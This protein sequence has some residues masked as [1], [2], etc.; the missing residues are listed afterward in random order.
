VKGGQIY[1]ILQSGTH[2]LSTNNI[3]L[4]N[5][6]INLPF[7][8]VSPFQAE[9]WFINL[10]AKL[11]IKWETPSP[12]QIEDPIYEV[13]VPVQS[14]GQYGLRVTDPELFLRSFV[15]NASSTTVD[16]MD[17][18]FKG[19]ILS[20]LSTLVSKK[21]VEDKVS[22]T[23]ITTHLMDISEFCNEKLG[24]VLD[25]WG[26]EVLEFA[27]V[28]ISP[29]E[30]DPSYV[31]LKEAKDLAMKYKIAG[32][33]IQQMERSFGVMDRMA[34]NEGSGGQFMSM[35]AGLGAGIGVGGAMGNMFAQNLNTNPQAAPPAMPPPMPAAA[36]Y[37]ININGAQQGPYPVQS[38]LP[39]LQNGQANADTL[40][41]KQ[42]MAA[43]QPI[44]DQPDFASAFS[45]PPPLPPQ[46]PPPLPQGNNL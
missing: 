17:S 13:I 36:Q 46:A 32:K 23:K 35:G 19:K 7:G 9:V 42:G 10:T 28:S 37:Y 8:G 2:T 11:D 25:K 40:C 21:I 43:W 45:T 31:K 20:Q 41:W 18:F 24:K 1:D 16:T 39:L 34:E 38:I 44:K 29:D 12:I 26:L 27:I 6:L 5:K 33:D 30:S 14:Y 15:G 4:L 3:P 22:V